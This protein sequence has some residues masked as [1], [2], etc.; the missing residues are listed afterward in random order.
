MQLAQPYL[1]DSKNA[2]ESSVCG[3][4][5]NGI[6]MHSAFIRLTQI[7]SL[8][9][10]F[11]KYS[12]PSCDCFSCRRQLARA[13]RNG[14]LNQTVTEIIIL[15]YQ[16]TTAFHWTHQNPWWSI[17]TPY[18]SHIFFFKEIVAVKFNYCIHH[19]VALNFTTV[20]DFIKRKSIRNVKVWALMWYDQGESLRYLIEG[21]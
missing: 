1:W 21:K 11:P 10:N 20:N 7:K 9:I 13:E 8:D 16:L 4:T 12:K 6:W 15:H 19:S 18:S 14:L 17:F 3:R 2:G 5:K